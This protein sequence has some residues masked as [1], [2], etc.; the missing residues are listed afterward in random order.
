MG[1]IV[2]GKNNREVLKKNSKI[3]I[4]EHNIENYVFFS[5]VEA[6]R[7]H[8]VQRR[9]SSIEKSNI[10][11]LSSDL[12]LPESKINYSI[13]TIPRDVALNILVQVNLSDIRKSSKEVYKMVLSTMKQNFSFFKKYFIFHFNNHELDLLYSFFEI[14]EFMNVFVAHQEI[15]MQVFKAGWSNRP[16]YEKP[17]AKKRSHPKFDI[18]S[19]DWNPKIEKNNLVRLLSYGNLEPIN[20]WILAPFFINKLIRNPSN[21]FRFTFFEI[22]KYVLEYFLT[23]EC[24]FDLFA[25]IYCFYAMTVSYVS[26]NNGSLTMSSDDYVKFI[27]LFFKEILSNNQVS[28]EDKK[29][30]FTK[31]LSCKLSND[32]EYIVDEQLLPC[33][34]Q[35]KIWVD[36]YN[37]RFSG[38]A[39][40]EMKEFSNFMEQVLLKVV[41][42]VYDPDKDE[43][44]P[45]LKQRLQRPNIMHLIKF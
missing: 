26:K 34:E 41:A 35:D 22:Y 36:I 15:L 21:Y 38:N 1:F 28:F 16:F 27:E 42:M 3:G 20:R 11:N 13:N 39:T 44:E 24:K 43:D 29:V 6:G 37:M 9:N 12:T 32:G 14:E 2:P 18:Y 4:N 5:S 33:Y 31:S 10:T 25:S 40:E 8:L 23:E 17:K 45:T 19:I 7:K 30:L